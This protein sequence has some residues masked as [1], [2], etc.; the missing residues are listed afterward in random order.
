MQSEMGQRAE[1]LDSTGEAVKI[2]R[3][4]AKANPDAFLPG[5][6]NTLDSSGTV[7]SAGADYAG[8]AADFEEGLRLI[9]PL[10]AD[11][12]HAHGPLRLSLLG[13]YR[14]AI[15]AADLQPAADLAQLL[16]QFAT[17]EGGE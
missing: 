13:G 3:A 11:L 14:R 10:V 16:A 1:V 4:L 6:A 17:A 5:L 9:N 12:P 2:R 7:R 15:A 8:A